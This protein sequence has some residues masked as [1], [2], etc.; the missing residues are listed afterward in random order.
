MGVMDSLLST[1]GI[2]DTLGTLTCSQAD[3]THGQEVRLSHCCVGP[4]VFSHSLK[5]LSCKKPLIKGHNNKVLRGKDTP[6]DPS[7][8]AQGQ[9]EFA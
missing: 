2:L 4:V 9:I 5:R 6:D 7:R 3:A 8:L 1:F